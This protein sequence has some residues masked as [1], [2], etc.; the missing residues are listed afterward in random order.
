MV[1]CIAQHHGR[2]LQSVVQYHCFGKVIDHLQ[3]ISLPQ[4]KKFFTGLE[5]SSR[6]LI[7]P[8]SKEI[9]FGDDPRGFTIDQL[10][11]IVLRG[12]VGR[13]HDQARIIGDLQADGPAMSTD[14]FVNFDINGTLPALLNSDSRD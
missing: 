3:A 14:Q 10:L 1:P 4:I 8:F 2:D 6:D 7:L 12:M 9:L 11:Y 13:P 5:F